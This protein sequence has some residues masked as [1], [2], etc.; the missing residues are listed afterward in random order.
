MSRV[1]VLAGAIPVEELRNLTRLK[2][3]MLRPGNDGLSCEWG[4]YTPPPLFISRFLVLVPFFIR[5]HAPGP[6]LT[7]LSH[8]AS[9]RG[10]LLPPSAQTKR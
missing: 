7:H 6:P 8:L 1:Y 9:G 5:T 3:L 10:R 2:E 4:T